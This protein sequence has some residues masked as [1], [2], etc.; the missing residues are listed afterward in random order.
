MKDAKKAGAGAGVLLLIA[1]VAFGMS[2][3]AEAA[4]AETKEVEKRLE[5][6][7]ATP[8]EVAIQPTELTPVEAEKYV[9]APIK[10]AALEGV[11][12]YGYLPP[13]FRVPTPV[14]C[15]KC[16]MRCYGGGGLYE[17]SSCGYEFGF[18]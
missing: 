15:P 13:L 7:P 6:L 4:P 3:R 16:N 18:I 17:C 2:R 11:S 1:L 5:V 14:F 10:P 8:A 9:L 12:P